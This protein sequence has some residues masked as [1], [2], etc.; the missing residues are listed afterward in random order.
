MDGVLSVPKSGYTFSTPNWKKC[1]LFS[2][3]LTCGVTHSAPLVETTERPK[4]LRFHRS[5]RLW[6]RQSPSSPNCSFARRS[7]SPPLDSTLR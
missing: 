5:K 7:F 4:S 2:K 3:H 1:V 6:R